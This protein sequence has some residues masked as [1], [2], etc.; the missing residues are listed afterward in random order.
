MTA[1]Q[2]V[3]LAE[4]NITAEVD[5]SEDATVSVPFIQLYDDDQ[6]TYKNVGGTIIED[7][8]GLN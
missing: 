2:L 6:F 4:A 8:L 1:T 5:P 7:W 3:D